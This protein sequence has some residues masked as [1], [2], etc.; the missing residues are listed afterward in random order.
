MADGLLETIRTIFP[1]N[2][3]IHEQLYRIEMKSMFRAPELEHLTWIELAQFIKTL[4]IDQLAL[5]LS[6][7]SKAIYF[8]DGEKEELQ[9]ALLKHKTNIH[10]LI[11]S[12]KT[13]EADKAGLAIWLENT[14]S[15]VEKLKGGGD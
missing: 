10:K 9:R 8:H 6:I 13:T 11:E 2:K 4:H 15:A 12:D 1:D 5:L 14:R 3:L 7:Q